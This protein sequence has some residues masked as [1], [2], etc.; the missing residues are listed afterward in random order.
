MDS[1]PQ[2]PTGLSMVSCHMWSSVLSSKTLLTAQGVLKDMWDAL[3]KESSKTCPLPCMT[4]GAAKEL[5]TCVQAGWSHGTHRSGHL[6]SPVSGKII[7]LGLDCFLY[8]SRSHIQGWG[9]KTFDPLSAFVK[10][11]PLASSS[12]GKINIQ[13]LRLEGTFGGHLL[14]FP[15]SKQQ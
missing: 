1:P 5:A 11:L 10:D 15:C 3:S 14:Q 9:E 13:S 4:S 7:I 2:H 12:L 8:S 6:I